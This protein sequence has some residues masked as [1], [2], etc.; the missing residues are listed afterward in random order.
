LLFNRDWSATGLGHAI[1]KLDPVQLVEQYCG[2]RKKASRRSCSGLPYFVGHEGVPGGEGDSN[3][4]EEHTAIALQ[5]LGGDWLLPDGGKFRLLDYQVPLKA[6]REDPAVGKIDLL[7]VNQDGRLMIF[8]LK[9]S[10]KLSGRGDAPPT[11]L[12]EGLRYAAMVEA[13]VEAIEEEVLQSFGIRL[14]WRAPIVVILAP[15]KW[16]RSWVEVAAAG[17]WTPSFARLIATLEAKLGIGITCLALEDV[18]VSM[19]GNGQPPGL[20]RRPKLYP[21]PLS[22][23]SVSNETIETIEAAPAAEGAE[24]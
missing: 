9:V 16:W 4:L 10:P 20:E 12:M 22:R 19:G 15:L 21:A 8:E 11:A 23:A 2:L 17:N 3:R 14:S 13:D 7:G 1:D 5:N 24:E 6:R 18:A